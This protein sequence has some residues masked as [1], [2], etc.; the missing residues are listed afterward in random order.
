MANGTEKSDLIEKGFSGGFVKSFKRISNN[1]NRKKRSS[2]DS[3]SDVQAAENVEIDTVILMTSATNATEKTKLEAAIK[4]A[5]SDLDLV[6][7][8][9]TCKI[10]II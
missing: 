8:N 4:N 7:G 10:G 9:I 5:A 2:N 6:S 1:S 3:T